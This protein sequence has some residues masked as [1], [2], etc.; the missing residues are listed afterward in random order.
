MSSGMN[1][2]VGGCGTRRCL[3]LLVFGFDRPNR[4][5]RMIGGVTL[6]MLRCF[7]QVTSSA[8]VLVR[9][10]VGALCSSAIAVAGWRLGQRWRAEAGFV[11]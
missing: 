5:S 9:L 11:V 1:R 7:A 6:A 10:A 2:L 3:T 8:P 4:T